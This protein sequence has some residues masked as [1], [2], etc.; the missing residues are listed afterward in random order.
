MK[1]VIIGSAILG[2]V[3]IGLIAS[4]ST[5]QRGQVVTPPKARYAMDLGTMSGMAAMASRGGMG[6]AMG[7]MFGGGKSEGREMHLRLG[8]TLSPV[9]GAPKADHF[10]S[11]GTKQGKTLPLVT[12]DRPE[13]EAPGEFQRP[14]G[15]LLL[16]WGCGE[17]A[18]KGQPIV[19][20]FAKIA[21][22]Q[23]PPGLY[24]ARVPV[25][26]GPHL[27]NSRTY[28]DWPRKGGKMPPS[29]SS[30]LGE[31]RVAGN[32]SPEMKFTLTQDYMPAV[33]LSAS[34]QASGS[35]ALAWNS[36]AGATGF[37]AWAMGMRLDGGNE[38]RDMVWWS[39]SS[40]REFGGG[41]WDWLSPDTV[42]R[43]VGQKVIMPQSQSSC[44][45]PAEVK[46][47]AP[48]MMLTHL[49]AY[50]PEANFVYP[51]RPTNPAV[52][53]N[54]EWTA[55]VRYRSYAMVMVGGPMGMG[56]AGT[57]Q[58]GEDP[59]PRCKPSILGAVLGKGC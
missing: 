37:H 9:G 2:V 14:K 47:A 7:M 59:T 22:G 54:Q 36:V 11:P 48:D 16:Y 24:S 41:L 44:T 18:A 26:R 31:Q 50:G 29:G 40:A 23:M 8:S 34:P 15:R 51:P 57:R 5:A 30:V 6:G 19:I 39:S 10:P 46:A 4:K 27:G 43:L 13:G 58:S 28:G 56:Q 20:D 45:I 12:P 53:W 32:Y 3:A 17:H 42:N 1:R 33:N 35:V 55:R 38:P 21:A 25:D 49:Y 52:P